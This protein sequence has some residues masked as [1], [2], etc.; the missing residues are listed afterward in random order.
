MSSEL[1][2]AVRRIVALAGGSAAGPTAATPVAEL[3]GEGSRPEKRA[4]LRRIGL[5]GADLVRECDADRK[6]GFPA[7]RALRADRLV[8]ARSAMQDVTTITRRL[9]GC[10]PRHCELFQHIR[11]HGMPPAA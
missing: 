10:L 9:L 3:G 2:K 5:S 1:T 4:T 8:A 6:Q 11:A 7:L